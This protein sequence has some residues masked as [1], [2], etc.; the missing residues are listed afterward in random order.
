MIGLHLLLFAAVLATTAPR[1]LTR[2]AWICRSPRLGIA[3]WYALLAAVLSAAAT[4]VVALVAPWQRTDA[5]VCV[6]WRWCVQAV[7]GEFGAAGRV[8][9]AA[10][11]AVG[12]GLVARVAVVGVRLARAAA[13]VRADH[14]Q[15]LSLTGRR[16]AGLDATVVAC[17]RPA[18]YV[19][20]GRSRRVVVTTGA[21]DVLAAD[22]LAAVLAH[23]RAHAAGRHD[24]LLD[25]VRVLRQAFPRAVLFAA[26]YAQLRRLVEMRADDVA[27]ARH[28]PLA[29]ARALVAIAEAGT[30]TSAGSVAAGPVLAGA[31]AAAGGDA[32]ER[33][34]R[35][36]AP[37]QPLRRTHR[38]ALAGGLGLLAVAP[39]ALL[40]AAQVFPVLGMCPTP[41]M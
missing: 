10:L 22:E 27:T 36:L 40:A 41:P 14:L 34:H 11:V 18:A 31:L 39:L 5:P 28:A 30:R 21:L 1:W 6:A 17:E 23:E 35:L 2:A 7:S 15:L 3:A 25:C 13:A 26:A 8:A 37:P 4:G 20:A 33:L 32:L 9:A 29:L 16:L 12:L 19:V 38:V 24:L